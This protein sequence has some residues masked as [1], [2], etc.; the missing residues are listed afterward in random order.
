MKRWTTFEVLEKGE[1]Q[2]LK[3]V[4]EKIG[5]L[6]PDILIVSKSISGI[7]LKFL[8]NKGITCVRKVK[9]SNLKR[10]ARFTGAKILS[11]LNIENSRECL[12]TCSNFYVNTYRSYKGISSLMFFDGTSP[13]LGGTLLLKYID[14]EIEEIKKLKKIF[15][16]KNI[17]LFFFYFIIFIF[18]SFYLFF[19]FYFYFYLFLF[20]FFIIFQ[21]QYFSIYF[22]FIFKI[23]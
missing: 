18:I 12:G 6:N 8:L 20:Y 1:E 14:D 11:N 7:A 10:I 5:K 19:L 15:K 21:F 23:C 17:F 3:L 13:K 4:V 22:N 16:V 2:F 9:L